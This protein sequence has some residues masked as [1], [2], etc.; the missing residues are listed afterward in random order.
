MSV[1][2]VISDNFRREAKKYIKKF[3]SLKEELTFLS[4]SLLNNPKQGSKLTENT[5]KIRLASKSK[6]KAVA[7]V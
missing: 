5:Y 4:E 3:R 7:F 6:A 2:V 1:E